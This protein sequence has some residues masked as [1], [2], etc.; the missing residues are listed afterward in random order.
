MTISIRQVNEKNIENFR[1]REWAKFNK[2]IGYPYKEKTYSFVAQD[3]KKIIGLIKLKINGGVA[4]LSELII[5]EKYRGRGIGNL[6]IHKFED[7]AKKKECHIIY[8]ETSEKHKEALKFYKKN[9]YKILSKLK[10]SKFHLTGYILSK[11]LK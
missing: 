1:K 3:N 11:K 9:N 10:N 6:L 5:S 4:Y 7:Y 8:L 2:E